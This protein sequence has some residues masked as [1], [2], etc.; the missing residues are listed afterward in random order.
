MNGFHIS[1]LRYTVNY[2]NEYSH[3]YVQLP[4]GEVNKSLGTLGLTPLVGANSKM[5]EDLDKVPSPPPLKPP[6]P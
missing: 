5:I 2:K 3:V 4:E 6:S 1:H